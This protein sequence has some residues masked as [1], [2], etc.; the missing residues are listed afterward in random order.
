M[1][2]AEFGASQSKMYDSE[3]FKWR[4]RMSA[5]LPALALPES[6]RH[7]PLSGIRPDALLLVWKGWGD[8]GSTSVCSLPRRGHLPC[9]PPLQVCTAVWSLSG[10][11]S[12]CGRQNYSTIRQK[13]PQTNFL[14]LNHFTQPVIVAD[15]TFM[16]RFCS[17]CLRRRGCRV[18]GDVDVWTAHSISHQ[19]TVRLKE[20][21]LAFLPDGL[22]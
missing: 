3:F 20:R 7:E 12:C 10:P 6:F 15:G 11:L 17:V 5:W 22:S 13:T 9:T 1:A 8:K 21:T 19:W 18:P 4:Q 16:T 14:R 2:V